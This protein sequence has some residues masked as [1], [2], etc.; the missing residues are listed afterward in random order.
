[1]EAYKIPNIKPLHNGDKPFSRLYYRKKTWIIVV[2]IMHALEEKE[3]GWS[4]IKVC[5]FVH[6]HWKS[7]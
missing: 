4:I 5:V 7:L 2:L 1:M 3:H 6:A